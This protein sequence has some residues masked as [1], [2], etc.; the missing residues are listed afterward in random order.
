MS[1]D[2][3]VLQHVSL[4]RNT[5]AR[6]V[7]DM[8]GNLLEQLKND[9]KKFAFYSLTV[10]ESTDLNGTAQLLIFLRGIDMN[11]TVTE[12]LICMTS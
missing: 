5:V 12:E 11:F 7:Q 6:R 8:G 3:G 9:S 4:S 2:L 1:R 10:D